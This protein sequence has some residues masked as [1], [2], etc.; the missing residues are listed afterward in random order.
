MKIKM[1]ESIKILAENILI[2]LKTEA[3]RDIM[4]A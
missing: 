1:I 3:N 4:K 2:L